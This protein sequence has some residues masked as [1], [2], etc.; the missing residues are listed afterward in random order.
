MVEFPVQSDRRPGRPGAEAAWAR[1]HGIPL[2]SDECYAEFTW[3]GPPRS[4]LESGFDGVVAVHSLSKRSNLAGVRV[5]FFAG[6]PELVEFLRSVRRHAGL[7]VPGPAQAAGAVA[8]VDDE[9]VEIQRARYRERLVFLAGV[10]ADAGCPVELPEGGFYLWVPVPGERW[11]DAWSMAEDLA[12]RAGLLVSPVIS[13][14]PAGPGSCGWRWSNPWIGSNWWPNGWRARA[15][16][17]SD[18]VMRRY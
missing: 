6:D 1:T 4:V 13:T 16:G 8:L 7:M 15:E 3:E 18:R 5:G 11:D 17:L 14:A 12:R 10:L 9:H 2:F